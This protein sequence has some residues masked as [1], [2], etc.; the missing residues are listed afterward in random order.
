VAHSA[1]HGAP[2]RGHCA[3]SWPEPQG[4]GPQPAP[5]RCCYHATNLTTTNYHPILRKHRKRG[6]GGEEECT[7]N[8]AHS[9][10]HGTPCEALRVIVAPRRAA[11]QP[12]PMPC[13][14]LTTNYQPTLPE[15]RNRGR[16]ERNAAKRCA[17]CSAQPPLRG[18]A[19][20][21]FSLP[22]SL[23]RRLVVNAGWQ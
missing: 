22:F 11:P 8:V 9:T 5:M 3:S 19:R 14:Y 13:C 2:T 6:R 7:T 12:A 23:R 18:A 20:H 17:F 1:Q 10:Q 4:A 15:H 21:N 16:R